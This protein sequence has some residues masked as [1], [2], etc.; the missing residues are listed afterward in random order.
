MPGQPAQAPIRSKRNSRAPYLIALLL[1]IASGVAVVLFSFGGWTA[2]AKAKKLRNPFPVS[3]DEIATGRR[4]YRAHCQNCHGATGNGKG[5]KADELSVAPADFGDAH[6]MTG[7]MDGELYY[8][9]TKGEQPMPSFEDKLSERQRWD[10][11][12]YIRTFARPG[13]P[14][15]ETGAAQ[16]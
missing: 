16:N 10:A 3:P 11:V 7:I 6:K 1:I 14:Q 12:E 8:M 15:T 2:S 5:D 4:V 13:A 9:I